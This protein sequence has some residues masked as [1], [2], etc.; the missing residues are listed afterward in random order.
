M[1]SYIK[2][3][4][5]FKISGEEMKTQSIFYKL[6]KKA[7]YDNF[8]WIEL[9]FNSNV[10]IIGFGLDYSET[11]MWWILNRRAR[12]IKELKLKSQNM[13]YYYGGLDET[14]ANSLKDFEVQYI[15]VEVDNKGYY[16]QNQKAIE[17]VKKRL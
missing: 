10:H 11:D 12:I 17:E 3:T 6:K 8:L 9:F 16:K 7:K 13:I 5:A 14:K 4:Y 15:E 1:D 2:G